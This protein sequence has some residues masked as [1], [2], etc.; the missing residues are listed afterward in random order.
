MTAPAAAARTAGAPLSQGA[1][2]APLGL[3]RDRPLPCV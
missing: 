3:Q 2:A 1:P